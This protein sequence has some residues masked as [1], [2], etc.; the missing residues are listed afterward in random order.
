MHSKQQTAT[1]HLQ[2]IFAL[3]HT[4]ENISCASKCV[5]DTFTLNMFIYYL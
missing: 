5:K 1:D 2:P 3:L 4:E